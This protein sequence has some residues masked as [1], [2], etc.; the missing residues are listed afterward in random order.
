MIY[1]AIDYRDP[2]TGRPMPNGIPLDQHHLIEYMDGHRL[3]YPRIAYYLHQCKI[4]M[5][6]VSTADAPPG[7]WYPVVL[8]WFDLDR[9]STRLNSSHEWISR[10]PSSA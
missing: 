9:K 10:M 2:V 5:Q 8:G 7:A 4:P 1:L 3:D 6:I